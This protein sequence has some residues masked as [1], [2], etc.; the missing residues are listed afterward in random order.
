MSRAHGPVT[1]APSSGSTTTRTTATSRE[2]STTYLTQKR[3]IGD[4]LFTWRGAMW[5][6]RIEALL[7]YS[8]FRCELTWKILTTKEN[9]H[10][11]NKVLWVLFKEEELRVLYGHVKYVIRDYAKLLLFLNLPLY[12]KNEIVFFSCVCI[13]I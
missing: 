4:F 12:D 7:R 8:C 3:M 11:L 9:Y 10:L 13:I 6:I 2:I 5:L 1:P